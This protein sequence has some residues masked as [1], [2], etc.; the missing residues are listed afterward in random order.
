MDNIGYCKLCRCFGE[1]E[2]SHAIGDAIF[3]KISKNNN[4]QGI[5]VTSENSEPIQYTQDSWA[6][7]QLCS[8]CE[9]L[10]NHKFEGYG[11]KAL[12]G[13][14]KPNVT[15]YGINFIGLDQQRLAKYFL[16]IVWRAAHSTHPAYKNTKISACESEYLRQVL[17]N[18]EVI[19]NSKF[20]I[21]IARIQDMAQKPTFTRET[22]RELIISP[23][24]RAY[25]NSTNVS[26]CMLFEG[27]FIEVFYKALPIKQRGAIGMLDFRKNKLFV[28]FVNM[29]DIEELKNILALGYQKHH[30]GNTQVKFLSV[31]ANNST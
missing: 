6:E 19:P 18:D 25:K 17:Q 28:P 16:S 24:C 29:F 5:S 31:S 15:E 14:F 23:F 20:T 21:K 11:L 4:G 3:K 1:L 30:T 7:Y 2:N 22:T 10:L 9:K 27:F 8:S 26:V 12:R 13:K